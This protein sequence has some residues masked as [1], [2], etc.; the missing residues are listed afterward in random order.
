M[1]NNTFFDLKHWW[2]LHHHAEFAHYSFICLQP[3]HRGQ[4]LQFN[5]HI[6]QTYLCA[7]FSFLEKKCKT[8]YLMLLTVLKWTC[9]IDS[10]IQIPHSFIKEEIIQ[11]KYIRYSES[12]L[13]CSIGFHTNPLSVLSLSK[14]PLYKR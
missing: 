6:H 8:A 3:T 7:I 13:K 10:E 14:H 1:P 9:S 5:N 11:D 12:I 4:R 2:I